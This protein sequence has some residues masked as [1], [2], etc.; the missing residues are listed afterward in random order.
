MRC[1]VVLL[2]LASVAPILL[3][4]QAQAGDVGPAILDLL[5]EQR[6]KLESQL[7]KGMEGLQ[8]RLEALEAKAEDLTEHALLHS[9]S[10]S[11]WEESLDTI[12]G[13]LKSMG[14]SGTLTLKID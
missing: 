14:F 6:T 11:H 10:S 4:S 1:V 9:D 2:A 5:N 7:R 13:T 8:I 12:K 3:T